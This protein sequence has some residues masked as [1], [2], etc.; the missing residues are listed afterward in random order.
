VQPGQELD[1]H[2]ADL[3]SRQQRISFGMKCKQLLDMGRCGWINGML[4]PAM[5]EQQQHGAQGRQPQQQHGG[6]GV[7]GGA[8]LGVSRVAYIDQSVT[9]E[10]T[11]LLVGRHSSC[12]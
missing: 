12:S 8:G 11:L 6:D 3:L 4:L 10:N 9:G 2:P 7:V 1:Y 5:E